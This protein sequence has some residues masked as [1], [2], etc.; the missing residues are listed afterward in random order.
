MF[1]GFVR[2]TRIILLHT[3]TEE[4]RRGELCDQTGESEKDRAVD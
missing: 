1:S 2:R 3:E 4:R